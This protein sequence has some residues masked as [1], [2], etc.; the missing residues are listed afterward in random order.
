[1][2]MAKEH[3]K[4]PSILRD[5]I[6]YIQIKWFNVGVLGGDEEETIYG[7]VW[8]SDHEG[9]KATWLASDPESGVGG[10]AVAVGTTPGNYL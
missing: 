9:I 2:Q 10:I 4:L 7:Y 6:T 8:Q 3:A 1:M 5:N